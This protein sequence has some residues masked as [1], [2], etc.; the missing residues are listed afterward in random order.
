MPNDFDV[1][2][3]KVQSSGNNS[4]SSRVLPG[5]FYE[6]FISESSKRRIED[7][8]QFPHPHFYSL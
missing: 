3:D 8:S 5:S 2:Q 1:S 4:L 6:Q 7:P